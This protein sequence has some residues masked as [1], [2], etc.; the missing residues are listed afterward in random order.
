MGTCEPGAVPA[1]LRHGNLVANPSIEDGT[2]GWRRV[3]SDGA[4]LPIVRD[5]NNAHSGR[6]SL[7][8]ERRVAGDC[9][10]IC[11]YWTT[12]VIPID[13]A[14]SYRVSVWTRSTGPGLAIAVRAYDASG[15]L[16][17]GW[18]GFGIGSGENWTEKAI[19][20]LPAGARPTGNLSAYAQWPAGAAG[21]VIDIA[22]FGAPSQDGIE[23]DIWIDDVFVGRIQ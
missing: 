13:P 19:G 8:L 21:L 6:C 14:A 15:A 10:T 22:W 5:F 11:G 20:I 2:G 18:E 4:E 7:K 17:P 12:P 1:A 23:G 3:R 9:P 16:I